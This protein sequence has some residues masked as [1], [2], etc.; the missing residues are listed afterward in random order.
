M[1]LFIEKTISKKF[2]GCLKQT[3]HIKK[4]L[5]VRTLTIKALNFLIISLQRSFLYDFLLFKKWRL[6]AK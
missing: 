3:Q 6:Y 4:L 2:K 1:K 5:S